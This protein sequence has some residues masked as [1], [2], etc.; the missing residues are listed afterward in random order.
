MRK[1]L[2]SLVVLLC[3]GTLFASPGA[4][5]IGNTRDGYPLIIP[6]VKKLAPASG[7]FALPGKLTV[8][9]PSELYLEPLAKTYAVAVK[10]GEVVRAGDGDALCRFE[11]VGDGVPESPEGY[12]IDLGAEGIVVRARDVRGL[13]CG[14]QSLTWIIRNRTEAD[15]LKCC[16]ITDW[17]DLEMRGLYLQLAYVSPEKVDRV[18][19]VIDVLGSL[20]YN[21]LLIGFFDNFP[22]E[23]TPF[24]KRKKTY[25]REDIA[26]IKEAAKRNHI[27]IVPKLQVISH[28]GWMLSHR[29]WPKFNEGPV[30]KSH[31][32]IY[33]PANPEV[34]PIVEK[35]I[36]E[37]VDEFK[38]RYFHLGLDEILL[39]GYPMCPTCKAGDP[40]QLIVN[41]VLPLKKML[42]ERGIQ[43]II[44]HDE[45][46]GSDNPVVSR[47]VSIEKVPEKLGTDL[48]INSW[49]YTP[50]P[51]REIADT[52]RH[53]GFKDLIYMSFAINIDNCQNLPKLAH[54]VGAKGNILAY[55]SIVPPTLD[56]ADNSAYAFYPSTIAQANYCWNA[57][58]VPMCRIPIDSANI[59]RE[60]LDGKPK[61]DFRGAASQVPLSG[62]CNFRIGEDL[63]FPRLD[64]KLLAEVKAV[65]AADRAGFEL[66]DADGKLGAVVL[67]GTK[68]DGLAAEPVTIPVGAKASGASFLVTASVFNTCGF[69]NV[70]QGIPVGDIRIVYADGKKTDVPLV[71]FRN[72]NDW[73]SYLGGNNCRPVVRGN[74]RDGALFSFYAIDWRNP[75]PDVEIKEMVF[76]SKGNTMIAPALLALS[77]SD[78]AGEISGVPGVPQIRSDVKRG[79]VERIPIVDFK[80]GLPKG[81]SRLSSGVKGYKTRI[82]KDEKYGK[83]LEI[84]FTGTTKQLARVV[85]DLPIG[86]PQEFKN[87]AFAIKVSDFSSIV[88]AD[89]YVMNRSATNVLGVL[90]YT[91][92]LGPEWQIVCIPRERFVPKEGGGIDP[93][94]ADRLRI[95]FFLNR[96][97]RPTT[98]RI[99]GIDFADRT[100][101]G[102]NNLTDPVK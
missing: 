36:R 75:R 95:G 1:K 86:N 28:A 19:R 8:A 64:A 89:C 21:M 24:T 49:Q 15:S 77:L 79:M 96:G 46:F 57:G 23:N 97:A 63:M 58:D 39:A 44:Y 48:M 34:L 3:A 50:S 4:V 20:K 94:K 93:A 31:T 14:M 85:V 87:I 53:R 42:A 43:T 22:Y 55:W 81:W 71:V 6:Q 10:G 74:D 68:D 69:V 101:P 35:M 25:T 99:A 92:Y 80:K 78:A 30:K 70:N 33:C 98:I 67:S 84:S 41:H 37:T 7:K 100:L 17:P 2:L 56:R 82:V 38:P 12:T 11:I 61:R 40:T 18:C 66:V 51:T 45:Y 83:V 102:R 16:K 72:I 9:A 27:E 59:L 13:Y 76:S 60:L 52:I 91:S 65:A 47:G 32:T 73:N 88:R 54:E 26:R 90:G 62:A 5:G 29:D